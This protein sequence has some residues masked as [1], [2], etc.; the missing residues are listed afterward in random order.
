MGTLTYLL[1]SPFVGVAAMLFIDRNDP[2]RMRLLALVT[3]LGTLALAVLGVLEFHYWAG[4]PNGPGFG[5]YYL[6]SSVPWIGLGGSSGLDIRYHVGVD[7]VSLWLLVMTA[8][9]V[10]LAIWGSFSGI[11]ERVRE[12]YILMLLL[13][14]GMLGVFCAM[15][16]LLFYI[17]FEFT[18]IPLYFI[19]AIWGGPEKRRPRGRSTDQP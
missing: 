12:Y 18:L 15:D 19:I 3:S 13:E 8:L 16:L 9:L 17:C 4:D 2:A 10:P 11:R 1:L 14:A 5:G 7:G 6:E